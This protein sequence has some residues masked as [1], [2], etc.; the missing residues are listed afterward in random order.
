MHNLYSEEPDHQ[1]LEAQEIEEWTPE[2]VIDFIDIWAEDRK[3]AKRTRVICRDK[4]A[5]V[6]V[7][8]STGNC[9]VAVDNSTGNCWVGYF[10]SK[11]DAI[12]WLN[13][14]ELEN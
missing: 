10:V 7:D 6:A 8:N 13:G 1:G 5:W 3:K 11:K 4:D 14:K 12:D 9:W 2:E